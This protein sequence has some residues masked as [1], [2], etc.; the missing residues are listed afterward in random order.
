M[1]IITLSKSVQLTWL[2][3][4]VHGLTFIVIWLLPPPIVWRALLSLPIVASLIF[5]LLR[6]AFKL[7]RHS[8]VAIKWL[9]DGTLELQNKMGEWIPASLRP[10][11]FVAPYL[12]TLAYRPDQKYFNR[13]LII[14]S[15]MLDAETFRELRVHLRWKSP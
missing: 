4:C 1:S 10:G 15:D 13:Y 9:P 8:L 14:L 2:L 11:S 6:D 7:L 5:Y 12:T 3:V